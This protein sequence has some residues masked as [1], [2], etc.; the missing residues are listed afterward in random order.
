MKSNFIIGIVIL[1][2]VGIFAT[3]N[4]NFSVIS[5]TSSGAD[6]S[7]AIVKDSCAGWTKCS[8]ETY[9]GNQIACIQ[10][11]GEYKALSFI[12]TTPKSVLKVS[13]GDSFGDGGID[14]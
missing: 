9:K 3:I 7:C 8:L 6:F 13:K 2:L 10:S 14:E 5:G 4:Y 1:L 12:D 11:G